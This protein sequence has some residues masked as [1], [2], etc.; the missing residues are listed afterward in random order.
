MYDI[1]THPF[2]TTSITTWSAGI[3]LPFI[4]LVNF[5]TT[6][7]WYFNTTKY[8]FHN[9]KCYHMKCG[10]ILLH[11]LG[12]NIH[13][14]IPTYP[15]I[16]TPPH[17]YTPSHT[18]HVISTHSLHITHPPPPLSHHSHS[19]NTPT[20]TTLSLVLQAVR[21][22]KKSVSASEA[23]PPDDYQFML[24]ENVL[25]VLYFHAAKR[26]YLERLMCGI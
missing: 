4:Y 21:E 11:W 6:S 18:C 10:Y 24:Q 14:F 13:H 20:L 22:K 15:L 9:N 23:T 7:I 17:T 16:P 2:T 3:S 12:F 1:L 25:D 19:H 8:P 5:N 26:I